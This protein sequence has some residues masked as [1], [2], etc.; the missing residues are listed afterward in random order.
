MFSYLS[1][2]TENSPKDLKT[3][4]NRVFQALLDA[5]AKFKK[6]N[7]GVVPVLV[8]DNLNRLASEDQ[9]ILR[10]LQDKAKDC[11]DAK[12]L[13][14]VFVTSEGLAPSVLLSI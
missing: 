10:F 5:A 6:E 14:F 12:A 11:A 13:T 7:D 8:I 4:R 9:D 3:P 2:C 1:L